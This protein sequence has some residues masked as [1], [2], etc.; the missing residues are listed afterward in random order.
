MATWNTLKSPCLMD[1]LVCIAQGNLPNPGNSQN[2]L[3]GQGSEQH[4]QARPTCSKG[5]DMGP[6]EVPPTQVF[7]GSAALFE[8]HCLGKEG[9]PWKGHFAAVCQY[10]IISITSDSPT[11]YFPSRHQCDFCSKRF[12]EMRLCLLY[13]WCLS[14]ALGVAPS[15]QYWRVRFNSPVFSHLKVKA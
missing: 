12:S 3:Q 4:D 11:Q 13:G 1:S 8:I 2:L 10:F 5:L 14:H 9:A 6:P 7:Y 15:W